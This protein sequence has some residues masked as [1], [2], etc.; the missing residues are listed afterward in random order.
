MGRAAHSRRMTALGCARATA[1][2]DGQDLAGRGFADQT[3]SGGGRGSEGSSVRASQVCPPVRIAWGCAAA[4]SCGRGQVWAWRT[5]ASRRRPL[6]RTRS[7]RYAYTRAQAERAQRRSARAAVSGRRART[8]WLGPRSNN[9]TLLPS[10]PNPA[11]SHLP[12]RGSLTPLSPGMPT[13]WAESRKDPPGLMA[14][15]SVGTARRGPA[16]R[17]LCP[18]TTA[19]FPGRREPASP[20]RHRTV[21]GARP[22][23][24]CPGPPPTDACATPAILRSSPCGR[25]T[26]ALP[27]RVDRQGAPS[28]RRAA[29]S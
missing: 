27:R 6:A 23:I 5:C 26:P 25:R 7:A 8:T 24:P 21:M 19:S 22:A 4:C 17:G 18:P 29:T 10:L 28:G 11:R 2:G 14:A 13:A 9:G 20:P 3:A 12:L 1:S 16:R 15:W